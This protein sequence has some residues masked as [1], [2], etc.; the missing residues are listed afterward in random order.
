MGRLKVR[1]VVSGAVMAVALMTLSPASGLMAGNPRGGTLDPFMTGG[2]FLDLGPRPNVEMR[3]PTAKAHHNFKLYC[4][5]ED[6]EPPFVADDRNH[7]RLHGK[8]TTNLN[9]QFTAEIITVTDCDDVDMDG[10]PDRVE[11]NA[12]GTCNGMPGS[13]PRFEFTDNEGPG[14]IIVDGPLGEASS[15]KVSVPRPGETPSEEEDQA[16]YELVGADACNVQAAGPID[17]GSHKGHK[18]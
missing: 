18:G 8:T 3:E 7:L 15:L 1:L 6:A 2:A 11:G 17:G 9:Y 16:F 5:P 14:P 13:V 10:R 12:E 4:P